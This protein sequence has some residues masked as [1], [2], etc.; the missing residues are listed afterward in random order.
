MYILSIGART[1]FP[2]FCQGLNIKLRAKQQTRTKCTCCN[3][4][5][6]VSLNILLDMSHLVLLLNS[7]P[8]QPLLDSLCPSGQVSHLTPSMPGLQTQR[9]V[10]CSQ[11]GRTEPRGLQLQAERE[12]KIRQGC[13]M[14]KFDPY[15]SLDC[16]R[17]EGGAQP[18]K[19]RQPAGAQSKERKGSNF[20]S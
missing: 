2:R 3:P 9:P 11:S 15:R 18:R 12:G 5:H 20:A 17:V 7:R 16:A 19:G 13:Q 10:V 6:K 14:A 1:P 8:L 4:E